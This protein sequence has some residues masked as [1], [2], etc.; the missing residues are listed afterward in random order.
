[1]GVYRGT[2]QFEGGFAYAVALQGQQ[3]AARALGAQQGL[4]RS[5]PQA[6]LAVM[7]KDARQLVVELI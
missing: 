1:L 5:R 4:C 3:R 6:P 7:P 2:L